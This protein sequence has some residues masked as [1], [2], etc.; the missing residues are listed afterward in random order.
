MRSSSYNIFSRR[1]YVTGG[2]IVLNG[3]MGSMDL[4]SSEVATDLEHFHPLSTKPA[5]GNTG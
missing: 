5:S 2:V 4:V 3:I 1:H